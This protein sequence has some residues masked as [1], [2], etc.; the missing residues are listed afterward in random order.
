LRRNLAIPMRKSSRRSIIGNL[1]AAVLFVG[2]S[3]IIWLVVNDF[4]VARTEGFDPLRYEYFAR[5]DLPEYFADSSSYTIV[6]L[7]KFI[8]RYLP[9]Y[10]GFILFI[11]LSL[12]VVLNRTDIRALRYAT[13]S[14]LTF[15]YIAQTGKDG[16][17]ILA[18]A[19]VAIIS[20]Q[21]LS[22]SHGVLAIVI[23][24]ALFVRPALVL[25]LPL[26]FVILRFGNGK[27]IMFSIMLSAAF[28]ASGT[29]NESL[30]QLEGIVADEGSGAL[31]QLGRELTF[32]YSI[33]AI[34]GRSLL[35]LVSPFI[36]PIGSVLKFLSGADTFVLFEGVCQLLFLF[37]LKRHRILLTFIINSIPFI[38]VVATAS[39]FYHFRYMAILYPVIFAISMLAKQRTT[40]IGG[41]QNQNSR[42]SKKYF[43]SPVTAGA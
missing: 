5:S 34:A 40:R 17:A 20:I 16:L 4:E 31:A 38:I 30:T 37:A 42:S 21:R 41:C 11:S 24:I 26:V 9:F 14:P 23:S 3:A 18:L 1:I 29:G 2:F 7:L 10:T 36:Q 35:L 39:P 19:C 32:G 43:G 13:L 6:L 22:I 8:Y 27:A 28:M 25:F 33:A 15:F 12:F